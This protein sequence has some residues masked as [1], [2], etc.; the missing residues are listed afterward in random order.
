MLK[1][2]TSINDH[3]HHAHLPLRTSRAPVIAAQEFK[4]AMAKLVFSIS[5][6]TARHGAEQLGRTVT[7]FMPL[8]ADPPHIAVS[9]DVTSRLIDLIGSSEKF[10]ISFPSLGQEMIADT[11]AGKRSIADR[12]SVADWGYWPSG[13]PRLP[14]TAISIDCEL[15]GSID[16]GDHILFIGAV[17]EMEIGIARDCLLWNERDYLRL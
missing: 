2:I 15:A 10:S 13:N 12:F 14:E 1:T 5:V 9:I 11:F 3:P 4:D 8:S 16:V 6:V 7:S 17:V